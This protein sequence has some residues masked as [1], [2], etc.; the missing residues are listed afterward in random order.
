VGSR[1]S[2]IWSLAIVAG[3]FLAIIIAGVIG[4]VRNGNFAVIAIVFT[5]LC[6]CVLAI[7]FGHYRVRILLRDKTPDRIIAHYHRSVRRI[8]HANA[9]AAYLSAL[10]AAFY[11]Q[12]GRARTELDAV[13]WDATTPVYR[14]HRM[15]VLATLALMEDTDY[16]KALALA[17]QARDLETRGEG[18]GLQA[19]DDVIRLVAGAG[20]D[21][22]IGRLE[23]IATKQHGLMPGMCAWALAVYYKRAGKLDRAAEFK[24]LLRM[25]VPFSAPM[26]KP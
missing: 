13:D 18:G 16:P 1:K 4:S 23:K 7:L 24:E 8:P 9:A 3:L 2:G 26:L 11:G 21:E 10:A 5:A 14:G 22:A 6:I 19:L 12:Y 20:D 15:Y 17:A 25:S